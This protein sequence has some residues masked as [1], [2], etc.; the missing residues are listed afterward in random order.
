MKMKLLIV[1]TAAALCRSEGLFLSFFIQTVLLE[2]RAGGCR[3]LWTVRKHQHSLT[4]VQTACS[5]GTFVFKMI[6]NEA[7]PRHSG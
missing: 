2:E 4:G 5:G 1:G 7:G 3:S 6:H